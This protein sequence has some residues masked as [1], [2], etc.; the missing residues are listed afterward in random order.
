M[1][2][3]SRTLRQRFLA[4]LYALLLLTAGVLRAADGPPQAA[5]ASAHPLATEA[6]F[7]ILTAGG[8][9]FDAAVAVSAA[10][11]VVEPYSSGLGGGGFWLLYR[12][13]DGRE[14]MLDGRERAPLAARRDIYLDAA[15]RFVP[16]LALNG[17][18]AAGIP[19][20][21]AALAHLAEHY[22]RLP[23][24]RSLAPAIRLARAGFA[25]DERY[26][27]FAQQRLAVLLQSPAAAGQFLRD[28]KV[29]LAGALITQPDLAD[30]LECLARAGREGLT[31]K[32]GSQQPV[33]P[34]P[35]GSGG[36]LCRPDRPLVDRR[37]T[38]GRRH[39]D[40]RG[41]GL[42]P[43]RGTPPRRRPLP[44][45]AGGQ[46]RAAILRRRAPG[47]DAQYAFLLRPG[48]PCGRRQGPPVGRGHAP[49]L[50]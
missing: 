18:L 5:I 7:E 30:T 44:R 43:G 37:R 47:T 29:P 36:F 4:T 8:N 20:E 24:V 15:G 16:E 12:A 21:P 42:L 23:L 22:G 41:S 38:R 10:L 1:R 9:A 35:R 39:L 45:L 3:A 2:G 34:R 40:P 48:G 26:R 6:G 19:G 27:R 33:T 28:G 46:C 14:L 32:A 50:P 13:E 11:A 25:V 17:P 49:R 31:N